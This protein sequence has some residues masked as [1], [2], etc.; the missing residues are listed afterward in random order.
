M[1]DDAS[2]IWNPTAETMPADERARLQ[3]ERLCD[4][5]GRAVDRV[6]LG[7]REQA[8][9]H[10]VEH[11]QRNRQVYLKIAAILAC[12]EVAICDD[13]AGIRRCFQRCGGCITDAAREYDASLVY[14]STGLQL[15]LIDWD[16]I[17]LR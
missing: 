12:A 10:V 11:R 3:L 17:F 2:L 15:D 6:A 5:V 8:L 16:V 9:Q 7:A 13:P 14:F 4:T 1:G